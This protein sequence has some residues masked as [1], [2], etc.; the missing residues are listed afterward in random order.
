MY[1]NNCLLLGT[2]D[3]YNCK[4]IEYPILLKNQKK[5]LLEIE[6]NTGVRQYYLSSLNDSEIDILAWMQHIKSINP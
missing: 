6:T 3:L 2:I 4:K 1:I 5:L